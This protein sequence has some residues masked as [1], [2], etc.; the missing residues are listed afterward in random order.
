MTAPLEGLKVVE[1]A[2]VLA[3]PLIGQTL[4]DL[5][6]EVIKIESPEGDETR[7]WGTDVI[8]RG[9]DLSATY[10][11]CCNRGKKSITANLKDD[12]DLDAVKGLVAEA[13]IF[14]E[15]FKVGGLEKFGL[16]YA[17]LHS[18][19]PRLIYASVTGF[20]QTGPYAKHAGYDLLIQGMSG[21]MDITGQ[22]DGPPEK[23]GIAI[24]DLMTALYGVIGIQA[25]LRERETSGRGQHIDLSLFDTMVAMLTN[26]ASSCLA[27]GISPQRMGST[28]PSIVPYQLFDVSDGQ[29]LIA[30]G[31][32]NLFRKLCRVL[33]N[34]AWA[35]DPRFIDNAARLAHRE[36]IVGLLSKA[37]ERWTRDALIAA[38]VEVAVPAAPINTV[39]QA[40]DDPQIEARGLKIAPEGIAALRTPLV[41]SRSTLSLDRA[42]PTL[43]QHNADV[44]PER[45]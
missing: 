22:P 39:A 24:A 18:R 38:L 37:M 32:N 34:E 21:L 6:A 8:E 29:L 4:A 44:L 36:I 33:G 26:Q 19:H 25:A 16:D 43:G 1:L 11:F 7:S 35:D 17:T 20:G 42:A 15:N 5:G 45:G 10:Y 31:N 23:L 3:G 13:D 40:L 9:S 28:H 41:F 14:V 2:R 27:T 12:S 30:C